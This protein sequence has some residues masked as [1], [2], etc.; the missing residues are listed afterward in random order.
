MSIRDFTA[1]LDRFDS[2][3]QAGIGE[4][5]LAAGSSLPLEP[6]VHIIEIRSGTMEALAPVTAA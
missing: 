4:V 2:S 5:P 1:L 3:L 6:C